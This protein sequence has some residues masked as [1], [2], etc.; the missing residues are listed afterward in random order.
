MV[1]AFVIS[2][3]F[4]YINDKF[5]CLLTTDHNETYHIRSN[6]LFIYFL[7]ILNISLLLVIFKDRK[8]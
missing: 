3:Q 8:M 5:I 1:T 4:T 6:Q 2:D 7:K